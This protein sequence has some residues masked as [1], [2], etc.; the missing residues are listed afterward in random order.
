MVSVHTSDSP[1]VELRRLHRFF[2]LTKAVNDISFEVRKGQV[3]G[4]I[5]PNGAGKTTSMRIL[6]TLEFAT[7][8]DGSSMVSP[9]RSIPTWFENGWASC[10]M[11]WCLSERQLRG[12][13]RLFARP[14]GLIGRERSSAGESNPWALRGSIRL[15]Q[16]GS[17]SFERNGGNGS[18]VWDEP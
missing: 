4:Y 18:P 13:P 7:T 5:G 16:T 12:V 14:H 8:G 10:R 2:G 6:A 15:P 1:M 3:F 17:R 11:V 9:L